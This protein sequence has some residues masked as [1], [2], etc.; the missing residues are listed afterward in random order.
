MRYTKPESV[1][2]FS[3]SDKN[4]PNHRLSEDFKIDLNPKAKGPDGKTGSS[5]TLKKLIQQDKSRIRFKPISK[6]DKR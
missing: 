4:G 5:H 2:L 3:E 1:I 6:F